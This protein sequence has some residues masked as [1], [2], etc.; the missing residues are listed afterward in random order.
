MKHETDGGESQ[1]SLSV[2][3]SLWLDKNK[4]HARGG[5]LM[6]EVTLIGWQDGR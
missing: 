3:W 6:M 1:C 5:G 2:V 4:N